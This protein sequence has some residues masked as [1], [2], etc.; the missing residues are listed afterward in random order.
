MTEVESV[1]EM[2][3]DR[4]TARRAYYYS[5]RMVMELI[6]H[7]GENKVADAVIALGEGYGVQEGFEHAFGDPYDQV[8]EVAMGYELNIR[9]TN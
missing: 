5:W 6:E 4:E 9:K 1:L 7:Y 3:D 8:M 2:E